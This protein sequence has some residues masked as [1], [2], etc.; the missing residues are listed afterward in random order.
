MKL[1]GAYDPDIYA[2]RMYYEID[3]AWRPSSELREGLAYA[4]KAKFGEKMIER[5]LDVAY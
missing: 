2:R 1:N 4:V 5:F 3:Q